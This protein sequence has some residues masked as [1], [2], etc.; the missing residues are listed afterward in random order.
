[1]CGD[2]VLVTVRVEEGRAAAVRWE[3]RGCVLCRASASLLCE[4][5]EGRPVA[6]LLKLDDG[7]AIDRLGLPLGPAKRL[8][9]AL[10]TVALGE[11]PGDLKHSRPRG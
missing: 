11:T 7:A 1:M 6:D 3:G 10:A 5:A 4:A 9:A 2:E 8:C